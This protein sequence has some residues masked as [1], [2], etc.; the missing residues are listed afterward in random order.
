MIK[1]KST[2]RGGECMSGTGTLT[3]L[4]IQ[5]CSCCNGKAV[6]ERK[7]S[8]CGTQR[9]G[10]WQHRGGQQRGEYIRRLV[11]VFNMQNV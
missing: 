6:L 8:E 4:A 10:I 1:L 7:L 5:I 11:I 2:Q 3:L 9:R